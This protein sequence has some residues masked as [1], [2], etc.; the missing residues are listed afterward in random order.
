MV[1]D[2][3]V[4]DLVMKKKLYIVPQVEDM[5]MSPMGVLMGS[6]QNPGEPGSQTS[7]GRGLGR[8]IGW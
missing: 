8:F 7:T 6:T 1:N 5:P 4:N 2:K 3:M